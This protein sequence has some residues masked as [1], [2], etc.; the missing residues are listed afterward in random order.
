MEA[1]PLLLVLNS[2]LSIHA[3]D[4]TILQVDASAMTPSQQ[5]APKMAGREPEHERLAGYA[6]AWD[7]ESKRG[8]GTNAMVD[9]GPARIG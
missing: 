9:Q 4:I 5:E 8:G 6:G 3:A 2:A 7:M 1:A